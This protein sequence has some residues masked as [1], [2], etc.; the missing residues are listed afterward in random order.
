[1]LDKKCSLQNA[2]ATHLRRDLRETPRRIPHSEPPG[3]P[4]DAR[5][6]GRRVVK[7]SALL[8]I[9]GSSRPPSKTRLA[10]RPDIGALCGGHGW[11]TARLC[12]P[13]SADLAT[14]RQP[15]G[16]DHV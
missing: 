14:D 5:P 6:H 10:C 16:S 1:M 8:S 2:A 13:A 11:P 7:T 9:A 15:R 4:G 3:H 12:A